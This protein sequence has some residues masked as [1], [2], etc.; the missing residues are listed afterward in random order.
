MTERNETE[1]NETFTARN[2]TFASAIV[3]LPAIM[4]G[5]YLG[6]FGIFLVASI[7]SAVIIGVAKGLWDAFTKR[8]Q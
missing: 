1:T 5:D 8:G 4:N 6:G 7:G 2:I 3:A